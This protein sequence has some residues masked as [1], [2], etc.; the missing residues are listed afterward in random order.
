MIFDNLTSPPDKLN[1]CVDNLTVLPINIFNYFHCHSEKNTTWGHTVVKPRKENKTRS[2]WQTGQEQRLKQNTASPT[3]GQGDPGAPEARLKNSTSLGGTIS[4]LTDQVWLFLGAINMLTY[5]AHK[6]N[7]EKAFCQAAP[8]WQPPS[9]PPSSGA[10]P[11]G[12]QGTP[13]SLSTGRMVRLQNSSLRT[14]GRGQPS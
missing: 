14:P 3:R 4:E 12:L 6:H 2:N 13:R 9:R 11:P 8:K 5:E 7:H 10:G 1:G